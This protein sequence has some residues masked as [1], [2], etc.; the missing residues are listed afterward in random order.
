M[1][2]AELAYRLDS[3]N[4]RYQREIEDYFRA[5]L[6]DDYPAR[7][8]ALWQRDYSS[9][10]AYEASVAPMREAWRRLLNPPDLA[11]SGELKETPL[12]WPEL[13]SAR[14]L[15]LPLGRLRAE[16][17]L[18]LPDGPGP[19]PLVIAQHGI[20][21]SPETVFG[22]RDERNLY[23]GFGAAL[24]R[25]GFAVL[26]PFNLAHSD[27]RGRMTRLAHLAGTT[28]FG[29]ELV[30]VQR[31]LDVLEGRPELDLARVGMWGLS[32]GGLATQ[33]WT[34]LE[35]RIRVA[36]T[37]AFFNHRP[38]K[39]AISDPRYSCFL[40][41]EEEHAFLPGWLTAFADED[42]LSLICPRPVQVQHGKADGIAWW[43]HLEESFARL[44]EHYERLGVPERVSLDLHEG[45]HEVRVESGIAWLRRFLTG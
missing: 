2:P 45:G 13:P 30:R 19:F 33:L 5:F 22:L 21:S 11:P 4:Q 1:D 34:P 16:A 8:A 41:T 36:I 23:Q 15:S 25:A 28:L 37:A 10:E 38:N 9:P 42:L 43:P 14:W 17:V 31:L 29:L 40:E 7:A 3:R 26:A 44:R 6:V 35:P 18:A 27:R 32:L 20:G 12:E 39:M 24:V